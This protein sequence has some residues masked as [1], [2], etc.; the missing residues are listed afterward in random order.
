[1]ILYSEIIF[2]CLFGG[3]TFFFALYGNGREKF[4]L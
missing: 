4:Y 2:T 3:N 1:M